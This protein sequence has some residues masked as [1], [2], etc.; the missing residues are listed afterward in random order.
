LAQISHVITKL[1]YTIESI[2]EL[3]IYGRI[4]TYM[5]TNF[6]QF[7]LLYTLETFVLYTLEPF[8]FCTL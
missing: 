7:K 8:L 3:E 4:E 5:K 1:A 6:D 2:K